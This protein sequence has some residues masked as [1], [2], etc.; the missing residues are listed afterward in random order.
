MRESLK[1]SF[2]QEKSALGITDQ[3]DSNP[4]TGDLSPCFWRRVLLHDP[5]LMGCAVRTPGA[6]GAIGVSGTAM[7]LAEFYQG[8]VPVPGAFRVKE[9]LRPTRVGLALMVRNA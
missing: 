1:V 8:F 5:V 4:F 9:S 2:L 6:G 7:G 3:F